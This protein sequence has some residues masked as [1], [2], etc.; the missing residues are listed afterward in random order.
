MD[1]KYPLLGTIVVVGLIL[2]LYTKLK[3]QIQD[4]A[5][6]SNALITDI[7]VRQNEERKVW[8]MSANEDLTQIKADLAEAYSELS[9]LPAKIVELVAQ[10]EGN[11]ANTVDPQLLADVKSGAEA[12]AGVVPN[13]TPDPEPTP[14]EP[15]VVDPEEPVA[16][17]FS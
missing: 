3:Q 1:S 16:E 4:K 5:V 11:A 13:E 12:L 6:E 9:G 10:V 7:M 15:V 2:V 8:E 17:D 14:E